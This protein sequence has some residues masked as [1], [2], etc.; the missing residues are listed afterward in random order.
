MFTVLGIDSKLASMVDVHQSRILRSEFMWLTPPKPPDV[1][2]VTPDRSESNMGRSAILGFR[3][4]A[5]KDLELQY[6]VELAEGHKVKSS[7]V[8]SRYASKTEADTYVPVAVRREKGKITVTDLKSATWYF[9]RV[10][11]LH[12]G[13]RYESKSATFQTEF[14]K[15]DA[16]ECPRVYE[17]Q[18]KSA[19]NPDEDRTPQ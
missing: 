1:S 17:I 8:A 19:E 4:P 2:G 14:G 3:P 6:I 7:G 10:V 18:N 11:V 9:A 15:P 12:H 13:E 5:R 16:P